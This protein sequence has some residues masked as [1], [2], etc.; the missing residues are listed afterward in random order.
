VPGSRSRNNRWRVL[1]FAQPRAGFV[2]L[3]ILLGKAETQQILAATPVARKR[4]RA[5]SAAVLP[6]SRFA[7]AIT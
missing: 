5:F 4:C 7:L 6:S 3:R 2:Q 1:E